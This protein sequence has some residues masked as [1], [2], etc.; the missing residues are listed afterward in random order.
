MQ[1]FQQHV[2]PRQRESHSFSLQQT[3]AG[4]WSTKRQG[5][6]ASRRSAVFNQRGSI[7]QST[8]TLVIGLVALLAVS[9][10]GFVYLQQVFGTASHGEDIQ[11][12]E[13]KID[14]LQATSRALELEGAELRSI[15][16]IEDRVDDLNLVEAQNV[17]YLAPIQARVALLP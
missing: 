17:A 10:L 9:G 2:T 4:L 16:A 1:K 15:Q 13:Q 5:R 6:F 11:A 8:I 14:E 12:L 7:T 3:G